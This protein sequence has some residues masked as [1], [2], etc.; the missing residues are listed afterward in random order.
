MEGMQLPTRLGCRSAVDVVV[1]PNIEEDDLMLA[2]LE[3]QRDAV[4]MGDTDRMAANQ[5]PADGVKVKLWLKRILSQG[6]QDRSRGL[7]RVRFGCVRDV[8]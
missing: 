5:R 1:A 2:I 4:G 8:L 3:N 6:T 7:L